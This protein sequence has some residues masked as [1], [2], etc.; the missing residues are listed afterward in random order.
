MKLSITLS[1]T[2][3]VLYLI[4]IIPF[5]TLKVYK[6]YF[7]LG[8][9]SVFLIPLLIFHYIVMDSCTD[10]GLY[11]V[12]YEVRQFIFGSLPVLLIYSLLFGLAVYL[13]SEFFKRIK[14]NKT[15]AGFFLL[16]SLLLFVGIILIFIP[17]MF[18]FLACPT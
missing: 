8:G 3:I 16:F 5:V 12:L 6:K 7:W 18:F 1:I 2:S 4:F 10:W 14:I 17:L 9:F 15:K 11:E 13:L